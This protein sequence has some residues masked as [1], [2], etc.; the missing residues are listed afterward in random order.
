MKLKRVILIFDEEYNSPILRMVLQTRGY[1]ALSCTTDNQ[2]EIV[3]AFTPVDLLLV[4]PRVECLYD[5]EVPMLVRQPDWSMA[6][7]VE[8]LRIPLARKRGPKKPSVTLTAY[9][10][11]QARKAA[12]G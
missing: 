8:R 5:G 2:R 10:A 11:E 3:M 6:E 7:L 1:K 9:Q 4:G 12:Q